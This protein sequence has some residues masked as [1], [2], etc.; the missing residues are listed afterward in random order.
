MFIFGKAAV[1]PLRRDSM[2]G[3]PTLLLN[4]RNVLLVSLAILSSACGRNGG[5]SSPFFASS[6]SMAADDQPCGF[7]L[8]V[9]RQRVSWKQSVPLYVDQSCPKAFHDHIESTVH[10]W[11]Q[12]LKISSEETRIEFK[13]EI[14][15]YQLPNNHDGKNVVSCGA[16]PSTQGSLRQAITSLKTVG[17]DIVNADIMIDT[18]KFCFNDSAEGKV[19]HSCTKGQGGPVDLGSIVKH[20]MGH[21][22]GMDHSEDEESL[23]YPSLRYG[24]VRRDLSAKDTQNLKCEYM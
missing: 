10:Q 17:R 8:N 9:R 13:G 6:A 18:E 7:T 4:F 5:V 21:L 14:S 15:G 12:I 19:L 22:L 23:M 11:N 24:Q 3:R 1:R 20:E 2:K 16:L